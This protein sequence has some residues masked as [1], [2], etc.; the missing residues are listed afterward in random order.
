MTKRATSNVIFDERFQEWTAELEHGIGRGLERAAKVGLDAAKST[1]TKGYRVER[2]ISDVGVTSPRRGDKGLEV[3]L[4]W[5][6]F[7]AVFFQ[8]GTYKRRKKKLKRDRRST[9]DQM[10]VKALRF[11]N[12]AARAATAALIDAIRGELR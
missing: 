3:T 9:S 5:R 8:F 6:D 1:P 2:I 12:R 7:R 10:G 11:M 4:Y